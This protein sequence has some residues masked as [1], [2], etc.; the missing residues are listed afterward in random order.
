MGGLQ[1]GT[2]ER[3]RDWQVADDQREEA[4]ESENEEAQVQETHEEDEELEEE[5][6]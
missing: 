1:G 3:E 4:A 6:G 2:N 5:V